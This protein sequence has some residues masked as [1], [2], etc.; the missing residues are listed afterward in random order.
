MQTYNDLQLLS[1]ADLDLQLLGDPNYVQPLSDADLDL[2]L[3]GDHNYLQ[4]LGEADFSFLVN[5][6]LHDFDL[7]NFET[8]DYN[9]SEPVT[10]SHN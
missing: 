1:Y 10:S 3:L 2:Q 9:P 4:L 8:C 5:D 7:E 6:L